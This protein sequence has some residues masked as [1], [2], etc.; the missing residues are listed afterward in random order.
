MKM[1]ANGQTL[2]REI[3]YRAVY[4]CIKI[5]Q[6]NHNSIDEMVF[7]EISNVNLYNK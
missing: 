1:R 7:K 2:D 5:V 6:E 3:F 4:S